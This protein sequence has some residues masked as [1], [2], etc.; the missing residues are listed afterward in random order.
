MSIQSEIITT[1]S[2][3]GVDTRNTLLRHETGSE[4]LLIMLPGRAYTC[5]FPVLYY[6]RK[7]AAQIGYDVLSIEYGFQA[8]RTD[9][10]VAQLPDLLADL[11]DTLQPVLTHGYKH[12]CVAGK[13]LGTPIAAHLVQSLDTASRSLLLLTPVGDAIK[14]VGT[15]PTAAIIGTADPA[16][17]AEEVAHFVGHPT[18]KWHVYEGLDH[19]LEYADDWQA[20][21]SILPRIIEA[22]TTF[23]GE[24]S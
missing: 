14:S 9:F 2:R 13:S 11:N 3:F 10:T 23:L 20:S 24:T 22:C 16:Y 12:I 7:V 15:I 21:A 17:V 5:D 4:K 19:G 8:A 18:V 6:L 1:P